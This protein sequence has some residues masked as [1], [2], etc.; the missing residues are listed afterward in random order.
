M[1]FYYFITKNTINN[2]NNYKIKDENKQLNG[3]QINHNLFNYFA[4]L[5]YLDTFRKD[6]LLKSFKGISY[7]NCNIQ[8]D[9]ILYLLK[10]IKY[11]E[12]PN[13]HKYIY[14]RNYIGNFKI[15]MSELIGFKPVNLYDTFQKYM[16]N[17]IDE[18]K[19]LFVGFDIEVIKYKS[20]EYIRYSRYELIFKW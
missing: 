3:N 11:N 12:L 20:D 18:L 9:D 2:K 7:H 4:D 15:C 8:L 19:N 10:N 1:D 5:Q 14:N 6:I 13:E 16:D 17:W